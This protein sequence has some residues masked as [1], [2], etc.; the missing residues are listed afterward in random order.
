VQVKVELGPPL[1]QAPHS[2]IKAEFGCDFYLNSMLQPAR[3]ITTQQASS[4]SPTSCGNPEY[5]GCSLSWHA[6]PATFTSL[7]VASAV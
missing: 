7:R 1:T 5:A 4:S 2:S 6:H 3:Q